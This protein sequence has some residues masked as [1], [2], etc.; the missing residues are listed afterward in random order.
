VFR[1]E[2]SIDQPLVCGVTAVRHGVGDDVVHIGDAR[3][4]AD[5]VEVHPAHERVRGRSGEGARPS[6]EPSED[7]P[8]DVV[9]A[10]SGVGLQGFA[11]IGLR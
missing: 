3:R 9:A 2:Q 7:E 5:Q 4:Q 1:R 6:F 8:I 11:A 10:Q